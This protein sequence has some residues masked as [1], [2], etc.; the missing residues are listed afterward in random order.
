MALLVSNNCS[1][2]FA[3]SNNNAKAPPPKK[4]WIQAYMEK[5]EEAAISSTDTLCAAEVGGSGSSGDDYD[6]GEMPGQLP[7]EVIGG[8]V[9]GV[10]DQFQDY[11]DVTNQ[12][13][14]FISS[15]RVHPV[16][17]TKAEQSRHMA[18]LLYSGRNSRKFTE[19][20]KRISWDPLSP[21]YSAPTT[22]NNVTAR[23]QHAA[24]SQPVAYHHHH[25]EKTV[26]EVDVQQEYSQ[27]DIGGV[28]QD[29]I[30]QFLNGSRSDSRLFRS[31]SSRKRRRSGKSSW[32]SREEI[33]DTEKGR[34]T[35]DEV[36]RSSR[37]AKLARLA[38]DHDEEERLLA[39]EHGVLNL[40]LPKPD[41]GHHKVTFALEDKCYEEAGAGKFYKP[42]NGLRVSKVATADPV[43]LKNSSGF[44]T[45][46][47]G[48][49]PVVVRPGVISA[50]LPRPLLKMTQKSPI[51]SIPASSSCVHFDGKQDQPDLSASYL[52][53]P[54]PVS[55][56]FSSGSSLPPGAVAFSSVIKPVQAAAVSSGLPLAP[57]TENNNSKLGSSTTTA[58]ISDKVKK[59]TATV[60]PTQPPPASRR[61]VIVKLLTAEKPKAA[62][63]T[64]PAAEATTTGPGDTAATNNST[65]SSSSSNREMH[66]RLEKNRR[67]HLKQC[68]DE[69]AS[70][71]EVD[72]RKA[73]NLTVIKSALKYIMV[74]R[75][76]EREYEKELADLVQ[77][78][79]RKQQ[80]LAQLQG[81]S[82]AS[83]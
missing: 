76:K 8:V 38:A 28:V 65:S 64:P 13:N 1:E 30:S 43:I 55:A 17:E 53:N 27:Q 57:R 77:Q 31:S 75:R 19:G 4:K 20:L 42:E 9:Q 15:S 51:G 33:L 59:T 82:P 46:A 63:D 5:A 69:L 72:A 10:I 62:V 41:S 40:S 73:S 45:A 79:I 34:A 61:E 12:R 23:A 22:A 58:T 16:W 66:N 6:L 60:S 21:S 83:F 74:L 81:S 26:V 36:R 14:S 50:P 44:L 25:E 18:H 2:T 37:S 7:S 35:N 11:I 71:C 54:T 32:S 3:C 68:F 48:G 67:A 49:A 80:L 70:E 24:Y 47:A 52:K 78:K 39:D 29:V 56:I